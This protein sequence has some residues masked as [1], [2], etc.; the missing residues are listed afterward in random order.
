MQRVSRLFP[1]AI[2]L[3]VAIACGEDSPAPVSPITPPAQA[4]APAV[5]D[6]LLFLRFDHDVVDE[7]SYARQISFVGTPGFDF[8]CR[9]YAL[10]FGDDEYAYVPADPT[11]QPEMVTVEAWI[12]PKRDLTDQTGFHPLVVKYAGNFW[13]TVDGYDLWYQDSGA[14]GRVGFGIG[15][16]G[17]TVR[18][19]ASLTTTLYASRLYHIVGTFDK[20][21]ARLYLNGDEVAATPYSGSL[22]YLGGGIRIG[23]GVYHSYYGGTQYYRGLIDQVAIYPRALTAEE[24]RAR[25]V[26]CEER[27]LLE[28]GRGDGTKDDH[29]FS[30]D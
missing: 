5:D 26:S 16:S 14:G 6:A 7:S 20:Y 23:G 27:Y 8:G 21:Y 12:S 18:K 29:S 10:M 25:Y 24:I 19:H 28:Y 3:V 13:N 15:T 4:V 1:A 17:G 2:L 22:S 30:D 11:L 9:D